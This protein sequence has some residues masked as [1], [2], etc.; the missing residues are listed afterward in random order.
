MS[1]TLSMP[2]TLLL[3]V[4]SMVEPGSGVFLLMLEAFLQSKEEHRL[5]RQ[6]RGPDA[7]YVADTLDK[8]RKRAT[9]SH[10]IQADVRIDYGCTFQ[11]S[12]IP[13][14]YSPSLTV[15]LRVVGGIAFL[16]HASG[17]S[18]TFG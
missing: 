12:G 7:A 9:V 11:P 6:L 14:A 1:T 13:Q 17:R 5:L 18:E 3:S 15:T 10:E 4:L 2:L 16:L 8:V